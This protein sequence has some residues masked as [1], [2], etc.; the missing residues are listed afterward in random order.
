MFFEIRDF[1]HF[2]FI[3]KN[4]I[5]KKINSSYN[6]LKRILDKSYGRL[7]LR[8][9]GCGWLSRECRPLVREGLLKPFQ[10]AFELKPLGN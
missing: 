9:G 1:F 5:Y 8:G 10:D 7:F 3:K 6:I 2:F 4:V